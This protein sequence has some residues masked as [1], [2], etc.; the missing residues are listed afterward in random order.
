MVKNVYKSWRTTLLGIVI[1]IAA[2]V[3]VF[4][5]TAI[6]WFDASIGIG[7][8]LALCFAPDILIKKITTLF[9]K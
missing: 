4:V 5:T 6:T 1:I 9:K 7:I 8:G 3:S 2:I